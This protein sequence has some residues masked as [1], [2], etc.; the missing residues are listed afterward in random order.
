MLR[1]DEEAGAA[2]DVSCPSCGAAVPEGARFC[3]ECGHAL[4][5]RPDERRLVTVLMADIVGFT[6]LSETADPETVKNLVDRCFERLVADISAFGG[7]LDKIVGDQIVAQFGAPIA[8]E[9]DAERAVRA[10]LQMRSSIDAVSREVGRQIDLRIGVNTGEV[11]VGALRAGGDP[12]VMGD[13]VNTASRLQT[14]AEPGQVLVGPATYLATRHAVRYQ[15]RGALQVRGRDEAVDAWVAEQAVAPPGRQFRARRGPLVGRDAEVSALRHVYKVARVRKRAQY[16]LLLGDAGVGKTRLAHEMAEMARH[17]ADA[18]VLTGQCVAYGDANPFAPIAEALRHACGFERDASLLASRPEV[19]TAVQRAVDL[20]P[21]HPE[22]VR[23][24]DGVLHLT[25]GFTRPGVDPKRARDDAVRAIATFFEGLARERPLILVLSDLHWADDAVFALGARLLQRLRSRPFVLLGTA[26]PDL[27]ERPH[28]T[29]G[30]HNSL[31]LHLDPLDDEATTELAQE[32]FGETLDDALLSF[33]LER[34]GGNPFFVEELVA[35]VCESG[36]VP[37]ATGTEGVRALPATLHGLLAARLDALGAD[38]RSLLED[39]AVVGAHGALDDAL[40]LARHASDHALRELEERDLLVIDDGD[41]RFKSELVRDVAYNTLTKGERARRHARLADQL[42]TAAD[43]DLRRE[44]IAHHLACA[45]ELASEIGPTYGVP[46]DIN[47]RAIAALVDAAE[48]MEH[49]ETWITSGR[50]WERVL[51][52]IDDAPSPDRWSALLGRARARDAYRDLAAA[53]DDA[54]IVLEEAADLG[55]EPHRAR[56]LLVLGRIHSDAGAFEDAERAYGEAVT[57]M[58]ALDDTSGVAEALRGL[59][60]VRMFEGELEEAERLSSDAL[61]AFRAAGD[62]QGE[63]WALQ[64]LAWIA[65][66][67]GAQH[68]AEERLNSSVE[69]FAAVGDWGGVGW[70]LGLLAFVRYN[71]GRLDEAEAIATQIADEAFDSGDRWAGGMM[72]VL[73]ANVATWRGDTDEAVERASDAMARFKSMEDS[74]GFVLASSVAARALS[75]LGRFRDADEALREMRPALLT[76]PNP[77]MH[78]IAQVVEAAMFVDRGDG[79]HALG[80]LEKVRVPIGTGDGFGDADRVGILSLAL[81]QTGQPE[82]AHDLLAP[83]FAL[84]DDNGARLALGSLLVIAQAQLADLDAASALAAELG[85]AEGGTYMD[86]LYLLWG[87][88]LIEAARGDHAASIACLRDAQRLA[89]STDNR[90]A[91]AASL[92]V[93]ARLTAELGDP[94]AAQA[95]NEANLALH[96]LGITG[97][98]WTRVVAL[99]PAPPATPVA[100]VASAPAES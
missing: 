38:L 35:L 91:R 13:V 11:V 85:A 95:T 59:G 67:K 70:A 74:Y 49:K 55:D 32:L 19:M 69:V 88:A 92:L 30:A 18:L 94:G 45:A 64:N 71:Q 40:L 39:F 28:L 34:S 99:P 98:G 17:D 93:L 57:A 8:H 90:L 42:A 41:F 78:D 4:V 80:A 26:R 73:R 31:V 29:S 36:G 23:I 48:R 65:F 56:A 60:L 1:V 44:V 12:T 25:D 82:P 96:S 79:D 46:D 47:E 97:E 15:D 76:L 43:A 21:D 77:D 50:L 54:L 89:F 66:T 6:T 58:R 62:Q 9:D 81:L 87:N 14:M 37:A 61:A 51:G 33:V 53:R 68:V 27:G 86:R 7:Y 2:A 22:I 63:A 100:P 3:M 83:A 75:A 10:A 52:L 20:P 72:A 84:A 24:V 16:V 5:Q